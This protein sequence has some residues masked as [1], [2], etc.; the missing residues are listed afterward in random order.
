[1]RTRSTV[2]GAFDTLHSYDTRQ[3]AYNCTSVWSNWTTTVGSV[4][5]GSVTTKVVEDV[6]TPGFHAIKKCGGL[7]PLNPFTVSSITKTRYPYSV[8]VTRSLKSGSCAGRL[9]YERTGSFVASDPSWYLTVPTPGAAE[10]AAVVNSAV[11]EA[12]SAAFDALTFAAELESTNTMLK[13]NGR[14]LLKIGLITVEEA[15]ELLKKLPKRLRTPAKLLDLVTQRWLEYRY[16]WT[17][18]ISDVNNAISAIEKKR[19]ALQTGRAS[20]VQEFTET[21]HYDISQAWQDIHVTEFLAGSYTARGLGLA[22]AMTDLPVAV[23]PLVTA[24]ELVPFSFVLDWFIDVG[25]WI[26]AVSPT[27]LASTLGSSFS[28]HTQA[29]RLLVWNFT[30]KDD[31]QTTGSV[32]AGDYLV[33]KETIDIYS[34]MPQGVSFPGWNPVINVKR[35]LDAVSLLWGMRNQYNTTLRGAL[36]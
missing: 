30:A 16:G 8:T 13:K 20:S 17:P 10:Q 9:V 29:E 31:T 18:L 33:H 19:P 27:A 28:V 5:S 1:M 7:L 32:T 22:R 15:K 2:T 25:S 26:Q 21:H 23:D 14:E 35:T 24:Y 11:A 34:R 3:R 6:C 36:R 4:P 12:R